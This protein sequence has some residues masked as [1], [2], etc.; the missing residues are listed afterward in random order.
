M[1]VEDVRIPMEWVPRNLW[2]FSVPDATVYLPK[3][4]TIPLP[5]ILVNKMK[6]G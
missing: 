1:G 6:G 5:G 4:C 2:I 3:I